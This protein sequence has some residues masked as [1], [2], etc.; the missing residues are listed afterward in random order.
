MEPSV[1]M[2]KILFALGLLLAASAARAQTASTYYTVPSIAS[3]KALTSRPGVVEVLDSNPGIF[4]WSTSACSA[5]D[6]T[7]QV[8]PTSGPTGCYTRMAT[9]YAVGKSA[10]ANGVLVT[11]GSSIPSF[12]TTLPD[13]INLGAATGTSIQLNGAFTGYFAGPT[14]QADMYG[15]GPTA[16]GTKWQALFH[17][18]FNTIQ[19][20]LAYNETEWQIYGNFA[21]GTAQSQNGT[22]QIN[23]VSGT[24]FSSDWATSG[25]PM[26][27]FDQVQYVVLTA[28]GSNVTVATPG[29]VFK[30]HISGTTLTIDTS[31]SGTIAIGQTLYGSGITAGTTITAGSGSTWTVNNSQ[32]VAS[33]RI[34]SGGAVSFGSTA[35]KVFY[36]GGITTQNTC[37]VSGTAV[38]TSPGAGTP[39]TGVVAN[40][41]STYN[42][43]FVNGTQYNFTYNSNSSL[44]LATSAGTISN[45]TCKQYAI[46]DSQ[47]AKMSVQGLSSGSSEES[48]A[49]VFRPDGVELST[50]YASAGRYVPWR[51]WNGEYPSGTKQYWIDVV[52]NATLGSSGTMS[53]GGRSGSEGILIAPGTPAI[54]M[55]YA[56]SFSGA[57]TASPASANVAIS[58]TGTGTVT[59]NPATAGT[60]NNMA[61]GGSTAASGAFTTLSAS[62]TVS[63]T[64]FSSYLAS[65]PAIG[66]TSPAAGTFTTLLATSAD[67]DFGTGQTAYIGLRGNGSGFTGIGVKGSGNASLVHSTLGS[68]SHIFNTNN[69]SSPNGG[70]TQFSITHTASATNYI[71][72]TGSNGGNPTI[73]VTGGNLAVVAA[74]TFSSTVKV[75]LTTDSGHTTRTVCQDTTSTTFYY[76]SGTA[77]VCLGTSSA[78]FKT[79]IAN[80]NLGLAQIAALQPVTFNYKKGY[81]DDG[82]RKQHGFLAEDVVKVLPD[83]VGL[84]ADKKP[85]SVDMLGMIPALVNAVKEL[86]AAND[87]L[88]ADV[89]QLKKASK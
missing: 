36:Y 18:A 45:A 75:A 53:L 70:T 68:G 11:D 39:F 83:L 79:S 37:Q 22:N 12:N 76:G 7:F 13:G 69:G 89:Q 14:F 33:E 85:N 42:S 2:K 77:G 27:W 3:L 16:G 10:M 8:T 44:T 86:K 54:T 38:T 5:A 78:R 6:D 21:N 80:D 55:K 41:T 51:L 24:A 28:S 47:V 62:S 29:A 84:D 31:Y 71:T 72:V 73:D 25:L 35:T 88:R 49:W 19:N 40:N 58:P 23:Y 17:P 65:P 81:G 32:T 30:G 20:T 1:M 64:G 63:G 9:P 57:V 82:V 26:F 66:G 87:N 46:V 56:T 43:L 34:V 60:I 15:W 4:N 67:N 52:P 48:G 74:T 59:I 61:I 50:Q